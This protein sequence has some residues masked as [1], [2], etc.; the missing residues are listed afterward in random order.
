MEDYLKKM[1]IAMI[2]KNIDVNPMDIKVPRPTVK[3]NLFEKAKIR[4]GIKF[5][6]MITCAEELRL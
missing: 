3:L 1:K 2:L 6:A 5:D 4:F